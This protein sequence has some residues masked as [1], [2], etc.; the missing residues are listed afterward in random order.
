MEFLLRK[1]KSWLIDSDLTLEVFEKLESKKD[2][3][4]SKKLNEQYPYKT[5]ILGG[6]R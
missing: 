3:V 2:V 5:N 1:I 4:R 6:S